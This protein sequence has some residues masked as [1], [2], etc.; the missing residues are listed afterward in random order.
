MGISSLRNQ[1]LTVRTLVGV[2]CLITVATAFSTPG[3]ADPNDDNF[4]DA[5]SHAG[6]E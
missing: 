1:P 5:L 4:I 6:V 3:G 2:G